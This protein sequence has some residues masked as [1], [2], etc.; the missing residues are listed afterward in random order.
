MPTIV[1][2]QRLPRA[3]WVANLSVSLLKSRDIEREH[4][5]KR[6]IERASIP[7]FVTAKVALVVNQ[8]QVVVVVV[9]VLVVVVVVRVEMHLEDIHVLIFSIRL[10]ASAHS[11]EK[12]AEG[13]HVDV[14]ARLRNVRL[15]QFRR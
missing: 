12:D 11:A 13:K 9:V 1:C 8:V 5:E 6:G 2:A 3:R 14:L 7:P 10:D 15:E 4:L